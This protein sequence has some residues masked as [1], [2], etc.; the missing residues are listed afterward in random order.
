MKPVAMETL[1]PAHTH[2]R[3]VGIGLLN[4]LDPKRTA[5]SRAGPAGLH[6]PAALVCEGLHFCAC[7]CAGNQLGDELKKGVAQACVEIN[8]AETCK[9][10][11]W[12]GGQPR[13]PL[14]VPLLWNAAHLT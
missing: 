3:P 10:G 13:Q 4:C 11:T 9:C 7:V 5:G 14:A 8:R 2:L 1:S 12:V 6:G